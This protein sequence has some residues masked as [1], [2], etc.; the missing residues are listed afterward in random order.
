MSSINK[1]GKGNDFVCVCCQ[2]GKGVSL[3]KTKNVK[4]KIIYLTKYIF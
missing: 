4:Q 1:L 3:C 2:D